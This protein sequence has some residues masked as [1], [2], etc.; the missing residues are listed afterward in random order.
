MGDEVVTIWWVVLRRRL[1]GADREGAPALPVRP[2]DPPVWLNEIGASYRRASKLVEVRNRL[3][4]ALASLP[5]VGLL[6]ACGATASPTPTTAS[7]PAPVKT[8]HCRSGVRPVGSSRFAV[9]AV[10]PVRATAYRRP[11]R[12]PFARF[13]HLN[14]NAFPTT[15]RV[16]AAIRRRDCTA[17]WYRVQLPIKPNG[18]EG[19][20]RARDVRIA[21]VHTRIV[22]Q[23]SKRRLTFFRRGRVVIR[24]T[25]AV[26]SSATP[27]PTG[28]YYVNQ[29]LVPTD[30]SG[31]YG[32][33]AIGISA[34]SN[35]LTGWAQGGPVAIHGTNE[36][37]SIGH[38]VSNGC[39]RVRNPVLRRLFAA[40]PAG[41][42]VVI[43]G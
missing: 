34:F 24:T 13:G 27:T 33:G 14:Q 35:V 19:Y 37:W 16:V 43:L 21:S 18:A 10:V 1:G 31:P 38:A 28:S 17:T 36:P 6:A 8:K 42:P 4:L 41:T 15:F 2:S 3:L 23:V 12:R 39:I 20:V 22:V 29:R 30:P 25:V 11:G 9:A 7:K 40:T 32:P 5:V 26:G